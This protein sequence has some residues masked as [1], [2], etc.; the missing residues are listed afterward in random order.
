MNGGESRGY[1]MS[2]NEW[3]IYLRGYVMMSTNEWRRVQMLYD[4]SPLMNGRQ[5]RGYMMPTNEWR[6]VNR[7]YDAHQ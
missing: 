6:R 5:P 2:T 7:L 4:A 1:L 3:R